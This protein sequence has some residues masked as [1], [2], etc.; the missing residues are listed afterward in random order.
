MTKELE[1]ISSYSQVLGYKFN[2]QK[3]IAFLYISNEQ[4]EF[5]IKN[6]IKLI[7]ASPKIKYLVINLTKYMQDLF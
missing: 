7:L 3:S 2:I 5:E 1:L 6:A 4:L